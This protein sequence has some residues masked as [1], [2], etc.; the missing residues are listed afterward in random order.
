MDYS[1]L[2][3]L[4]KE[5]ECWMDSKRSLFQ[6]FGFSKSDLDDAPVCKEPRFGI[7]LLIKIHQNPSKYKGFK[8]LWTKHFAKSAH[9]D[10]LK[11][12]SAMVFEALKHGISVR[13]Y[14]SY[15][16]AD[17][18]KKILLDKIDKAWIIGGLNYSTVDGTLARNYI[19]VK[20]SFNTMRIQYLYASSN[21]KLDK[22]NS[23]I[24]FG[25]SGIPSNNSF[26]SGLHMLFREHLFSWSIHSFLMAPEVE[27]DML[28]MLEDYKEDFNQFIGKLPTSKQNDIYRKFSNMR[29]FNIDS[30]RLVYG[31]HYSY[32]Q[33]LKELSINK[34]V[35]EV[36]Q[37]TL[38]E[39]GTELLF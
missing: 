14:P 34:Q 33:I 7:F 19:I 22:D 20:D 15:T 5:V 12:A 24:T 27:F 28:K 31:E 26:E 38:P 3:A 21:L 39:L 36:K 10:A 1:K 16:L 4:E 18:S 35:L 2:E 30:F 9:P 17:H 29:D 23:D 11:S 6:R 13:I 32:Y 25:S 37:E 8:S